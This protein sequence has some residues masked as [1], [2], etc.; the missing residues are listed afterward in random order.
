LEKPVYVSG[1]VTPQSLEVCQTLSAVTARITDNVGVATVNVRIVD[2]AGNQLTSFGAYRIEGNALA[3][4][5]RND[6]VVPCNATTGKY[7]AE[8]MALDA[9]RNATA[10]T[11]VGEF[12]VNAAAKPDTVAPTVVTGSVS[13]ATVTVCK[14]ITEIKAQVTD[15]TRVK[16]VVGGLFNAAGANVALETLYLRSGTALDG[17]WLNDLTVPCSVAPGTYSVM[18]RGYDQW[19][20]SSAWKVIG[21]ISVLAA[22]PV[23]APT[24]TPTPSP[25]PTPTPTPIAAPAPTPTPTPIAKSS[26]TIRMSTLVDW[27]R[28]AAQPISAVASSGLPISYTSLTP[29]VCY[30]I[31]SSSGTVI[32]RQARLVDSPFWTCTIRAAQV[33]DARFN[34]APAVDTTFKFLK[35]RTA[36]AVT[37]SSSLVGAGPHQ[38]LSTFGFVDRTMMSGLTS[39]ATLLTVTSQ[40]PSV[41][42]VSR[43][44]LWDRT[45]GVIN[46][47][48]VTVSASGTCTLKFDFPGS[49]DRLPS[50]LTWNA[51]A[52]R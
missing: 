10:W 12:T 15:D 48:F 45:G 21:S 13:Q 41:C 4:S 20:K 26:Q 30:L 47:T 29:E 2:P 28:N 24:P 8:V 31:N 36:I 51:T 11:L 46:R 7:R 40:T 49:A 23:V 9:A 35:A 1:S 16:N 22:T 18:A 25:T 17:L 39:L 14:T 52:R 34:P 44:E 27:E 6:W 43:N 3:G 38:V 19:D 42:Q 33:G 50:T 32:Q 37:S 5:Y